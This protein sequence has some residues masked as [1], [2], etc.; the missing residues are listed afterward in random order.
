[1]NKLTKKQIE[2]TFLQNQFNELVIEKLQEIMQLQNNI[3][4]DNLEYT[5][6]RRKIIISE[7]THYVLF[8]FT[9][10]TREKFVIRRC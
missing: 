5:A 8:I 10:Y 4:L 1:M 6:K 3:K 7:N 2:S 9:R